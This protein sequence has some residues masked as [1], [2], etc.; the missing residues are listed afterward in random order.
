MVQI[1]LIGIGVGAAAALLFASLISGSLL[2]IFLFY[3]SPLPIL[4]AAIGWSHWAALWAALFAAVA[5]ALV[6]G[7]F[8]FLAFLIGVGLPAWWLGYLALLAR[9]SAAGDRLEWYPPGNLVVWAALLGALIVVAALPSLGTDEASLRATLKS[10]IERVLRMQMRTPANAPLELPGR[11]DLNRVVDIL[12]LL[13]P[14]AAAVFATL[15]NALNL[16]LAGRIIKVSNRL[17]RPWPDVSAMTFPSYAPLLVAAAAIGS[18]FSG[19]VGLVSSV[20]AASLL[21]AYAV[22]GFA[23]L[24]SITR[25]MDSRGFVLAGVYAAVA[26]F[27]W[28]ILVMTLL[29]FADTA[30]DI[31]GR[32]RRRR[33]PAPP[34]PPPV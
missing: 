14:P 9:P 21:M 3:L 13:I 19:T 20:L 5:L 4:I 17:K 30:L 2:S 8:F 27:Y 26:M 28:P 24:H 34:P 31:R 18:F 11:A 22:L 10:G 25:G 1:L 33:P 29:G 7:M 23:V 6:F 12:I 15:T 16:W 32:V